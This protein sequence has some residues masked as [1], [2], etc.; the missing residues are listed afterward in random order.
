MYGF[1]DIEKLKS[2]GWK[3]TRVVDKGGLYQEEFMPVDAVPQVD[4]F[5]A[6]MDYGREHGKKVTVIFEEEELCN[7]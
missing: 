1:I 2:E 6:L 4:V 3:L 5:R 7:D